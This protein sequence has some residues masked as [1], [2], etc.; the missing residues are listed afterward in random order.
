MDPVESAACVIIGVFALLF[1]REGYSWMTAPAP[2]ATTSV[3]LTQV[4]DQTAGTPASDEATSHTDGVS[5]SADV[6][7]FAA[8]MGPAVD[9]NPS[10][11]DEKV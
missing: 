3:E 9:E 5:F 10:G 2:T 4:K 7:A 6:D 1:S 8:V 11:D